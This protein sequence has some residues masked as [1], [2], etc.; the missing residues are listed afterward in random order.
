MSYVNIIRCPECGENVSDKALSCPNC[1]Y[2]FEWQKK[3]RLR[4]ILLGGFLVVIVLIITASLIKGN[5]EKQNE[6]K[7]EKLQLQA[8]NY[9]DEMDLDSAE[10]CCQSLKALGVDTEELEKKIGYD[11][12]KYDTALEFHDA[13]Q[14]A[15]EKI[16]VGIKN[17]FTGK[18]FFEILNDLTGVTQDFKSILFSINKDSNVGKYLREISYNASLDTLWSDILVKRATVACNNTKVNAIWVKSVLKQLL[19]VEFPYM[20]E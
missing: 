12:E 17:N 19:D 5:I 20:K 9:Y 16:E 15:Y 6:H 10:E 18:E 14:T 13:V 3:K 7:I 8:D 2:S 11:R 4:F 1:G